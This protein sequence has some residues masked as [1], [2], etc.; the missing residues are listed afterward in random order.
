MCILWCSISKY[1]YSF[2]DTEY[3]SYV[4]TNSFSFLYTLRRHVDKICHT[5]G[6]SFIREKEWR[7]DNIEAEAENE[8]KRERESKTR[9]NDDYGLTHTHIQAEEQSA[10]DHRL[11]VT[12]SLF[13]SLVSEEIGN[14]NYISCYKS[15]V[16]C[17]Y[18]IQTFVTIVT[19]YNLK[20][21]SI[22]KVFVDYQKI[23]DCN[24]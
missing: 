9:S 21:V 15:L 11:T 10:I 20:T 2:N 13:E 24:E 3:D 23:I 17:L 5:E 4:N 8:R 1:H 16:A 7:W 19:C 22:T 6:W 12:R 14:K 18:S